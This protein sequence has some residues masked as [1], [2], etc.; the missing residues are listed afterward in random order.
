M[1]SRR[2]VVTG[3]GAITPIGNSAEELWTALTHGRSGIGPITKFDAL[4]KNAQGEFLYPTRI[5][6]EV[7]NFD[8]L[9]Y[10]TRRRR[11]ASTRSSSTRWPAA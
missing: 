9:Q 6:G 11:G 7:R 4:V 10:V 2:V 3:L 1:D 8:P 5:A